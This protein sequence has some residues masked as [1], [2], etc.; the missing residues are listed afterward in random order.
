M[1]VDRLRGVDDEAVRARLLRSAARRSISIRRLLLAFILVG[2]IGGSANWFI[3]KTWPAMRDYG[4]ITS[5]ATAAL[6]L[7]VLFRWR[8]RRLDR[9]LVDVL[10]EEGRCEMCGYPRTADAATCPECGTPSDAAAAD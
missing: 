7:G 6:L 2:V 8:F 3:K 9:S 4:S 5:A 1:A 10:R